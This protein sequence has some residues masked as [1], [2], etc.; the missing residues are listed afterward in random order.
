MRSGRA[1]ATLRAEVPMEPVEP[2][3]RTRF[4][5]AGTFF[6]DRIDGILED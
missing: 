4:L 5:R 1:R 3:R 6:G 2:R